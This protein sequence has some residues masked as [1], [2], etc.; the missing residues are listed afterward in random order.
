MQADNNAV[1]SKTVSPAGWITPNDLEYERGKRSY[2][3]IK[4][5]LNCAEKHTHFSSVSLVLATSSCYTLIEATMQFFVHHQT[6]CNKWFLFSTVHQHIEVI[7]S[8]FISCVAAFLQM[9]HDDCFCEVTSGKKQRH[10]LQRHVH[11]CR[12]QEAAGQNS[13]SGSCKHISCI[14]NLNHALNLHDV[15]ISGNQK[16]TLRSV[17][18]LNLADLNSSH[19]FSYLPRISSDVVFPLTLLRLPVFGLRTESLHRY[20]P[21]SAHWTAFKSMDRFAEFWSLSRRS[22]RPW[23]LSD[24]GGSIDSSVLSLSLTQYRNGALIASSW[25]EIW[26]G[27]ITSWPKVAVSIGGCCRVSWEAPGVTYKQK[28]NTD[29]IL[30]SHRGFPVKNNHHWCLQFLPVLF[31]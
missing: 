12:E 18:D 2:G 15:Y 16:F 31:Y 20:F 25:W 13:Y 17:S 1:S 22:T 26:H 6:K 7:K 27:I 11:V 19:Q 10:R 3:W 24:W 8:R 28:L 9:F 5:Y 21:L 30:G 29:R 23:Y 4:L 14:W